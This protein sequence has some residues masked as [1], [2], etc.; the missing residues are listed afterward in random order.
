MSLI[1]RQ[2]EEAL[3]DYVNTLDYTD[4]KWTAEDVYDF[5]IT[6]NPDNTYHHQFVNMAYAVYK[7]GRDP[8]VPFSEPQQL[9]REVI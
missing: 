1:Q 4:E 8:I 7:A 6:K 3:K 2:F 9:L 5:Y